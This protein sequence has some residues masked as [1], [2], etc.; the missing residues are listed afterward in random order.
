MWTW[1]GGGDRLA[2]RTS[3][4]RRGRVEERAAH[5]PSVGKAVGREVW[6]ESGGPDVSLLVLEGQPR[7]SPSTWNSKP[8]C[9][10]LH[11]V[12]VIWLPVVWGPDLP[13]CTIDF[14]LAHPPES[15]KI[16]VDW[17]QEKKHFKLI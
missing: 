5:R 15:R 3:H 9:T 17:R 2:E 11:L 8:T 12:S 13:V 6:G 16:G 7:R 1:R 14:F 4:W 10:N